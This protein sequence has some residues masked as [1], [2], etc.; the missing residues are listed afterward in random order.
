MMKLH[1]AKLA[2]VSAFALGAPFAPAHAQT[3]DVDDVEAADGG[4]GVGNVIVVTAQ[5]RAT[6]LQ[7]TPIAI[8]ALGGE[9]LE[10]RGVDTAVD[11][12]MFVPGADFSTNGGSTSITIRGVGSDGLSQPK[13]DP[14][15]AAHLDGVYLAR[16]ASLG[17][18]LYD[19]ERIEVLRGPQG[20][21]YGR[22]AT[23]GAL[24]II[25]KMPTD[26]FQF[27]GDLTYGNYDAV[28]ARGYVNIPFAE[29]L[30]FR[31]SLIYNRHDGYSEQLNPAFDDGDDADDIAGR[32]TLLWEPSDRVSLALRANFFRSDTVG[33]QRTLLDT[34]SLLTVT[35]ASG[36]PYGS[37][38]GGI[39]IDRCGFTEFPEA[40]TNPRAQFDAY[41]PSQLITSNTYSA[42]LEVDMTNS[43]TLRSITGYTEFVQDKDSTA[44]PFEPIT[45]NATFDFRT[46]SDALTQELN[47]AYDAGGRLTL[48]VGAFYLHDDGLNLFTE[49]PNNP[50]TSVAITSDQTVNTESYA[51]FGDASF[52]IAG[53]FSVNGGIRYTNDT[54]SGQ[55]ITTVGLPFQAPF[56]VPYDRALKFDSLDYKIG[57]DWEINDDLFAYANY[58]TAFKAGGV[59]T[60]IPVNQTFEPERL[61]AFQFG[62]RSEFLERLVQ[63]NL[64]GYYYDYEDP[65]ITQ[66][67]GFAL[68]TQ[69]VAGAESYGAELSVAAEPAPGLVIAGYLAYNQSSYSDGLITDIIDQDP[70]GQN[71]FGQIQIGGNPLRFTPEW[72]FSISPTYTFHLSDST[73]LVARA[74]YAWQD[75]SLARPH[76]LEID[77]I[78]SYQTLNASLRANFADGQYFAEIFGRNL[79]DETVV[80]AR[81]VNPLHVAE[82]RAPRTYGVTIG[83]NFD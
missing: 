59:N 33:P 68:E 69:N 63:I 83:V 4:S 60:G 61:R 13:D 81:F 9:A 20:T 26:R 75:D 42:T 37:V 1:V 66:V 27:G 18:M 19:I 40:C 45:N 70:F 82:Y 3:T 8:T 44:H 23:G 35:D 43:I 32:A 57:V 65:Q 47:L 52:E 79:T 12:A 51:F 53:G 54:K 64:D 6:D 15:V 28:Q 36:T 30:G 24:N 41:E 55:S 2:T 39:I 67:L 11:L 29:T 49:V 5:K 77:E 78:D 71:V 16:P 38:T 25:T 56:S 48:V 14:S 73:E 62:V 17:A 46:G 72:S 31:G 80:S 76:G 34:Q 22:N 7:V 58:S 50:M 21:L 10:A 74:D